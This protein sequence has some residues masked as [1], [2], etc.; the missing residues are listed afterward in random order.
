MGLRI[1]IIRL[2]SLGDVIIGA[3][4]LPFV[5]EQLQERLQQQVEITWIVDSVFAEVLQDSP[6]VDRLVEVNLKKGGARAIAGIIR[7]LRVLPYYDK[8]IDMQG[9]IKSAVCGRFLK[10]S[11]FWGF[12]KDSVKERVASL[13]YKKRVKIPY[14]NHILERNFVLMREALG[15]ENVELKSVYT[16]R[17]E[18]FFISQRAEKQMTI[19]MQECAIDSKKHLVLLVLESSLESKTYPPHLF[20]EVIKMLLSNPQ[21]Q[22]LLLWYSTNK[23]QEIKVCFENKD[24][25]LLPRLCMGEIK[26]L[27]GQVSV[28]VGGDTGITHLA[29]AMQKPSVTLYGNTPSSRFALVSEV[30][31][32]LSGSE[33]P[34][35]QKND[36]SIANIAPSAVAAEINTILQ[37]QHSLACGK[38]L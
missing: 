28:V 6:C 34:S 19:I 16:K 24:V 14:E 9:L 37:R 5:R 26:A 29:W 36:F 25:V 8:V 11:E 35:Y 32:F 13:L 22:V 7:E 31:V 15:L 17:K 20:V 4:V 21:I 38:E 30:N 1:A 18:A 27:I 33:N 10:F 3:C 12:D 23:A 2:S